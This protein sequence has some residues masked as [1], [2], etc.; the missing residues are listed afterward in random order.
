MNELKQFQKNIKIRRKA[1]KRKRK[2]NTIVNQF[3]QQLKVLKPINKE[4]QEHIKRLKQL[5]DKST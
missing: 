3:K 2:I 4:R 1:Q 5:K